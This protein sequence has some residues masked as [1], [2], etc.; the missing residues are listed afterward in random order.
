MEVYYLLLLIAEHLK[1]DKDHNQQYGPAY[2]LALKYFD[3][4][5]L[6][7]RIL[8]LQLDLK[9]I[10]ENPSPENLTKLL[11]L[12]PVPNF[13]D[14]PNASFVKVLK[15]PRDCSKFESDNYFQSVTVHNGFS[16]R[17]SDFIYGFHRENYITGYEPCK[18]HILLMDRSSQHCKTLNT[19]QARKFI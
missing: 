9:V 14:N 18:K 7:Q 13:T 6:V 15:K 17:I 1:V 8:L 10:Y 4:Q 12:F 5:H 2:N 11:A 16:S 3:F 19:S